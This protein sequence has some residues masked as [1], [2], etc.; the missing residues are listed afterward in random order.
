[1][2]PTHLIYQAL[3]EPCQ[4]ET[5]RLGGRISG[6][7]HP[8]YGKHHKPESIKKMRQNVP[9]YTGDKNP[10]FEIRERDGRNCQLCLCTEEDNGQ[11]LDVHH[12][13][14]DKKNCT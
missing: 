1:M 6:K 14:Y 11:K 7:N 13:H 12:I 3:G 10:F 8:M 9:D 2:N 4:R 5:L